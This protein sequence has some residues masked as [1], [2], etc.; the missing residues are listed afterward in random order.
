[1]LAAGDGTRLRP[2]TDSV[3]KCLLP[4]RGTPMLE[5]WLELCRSFGIDEV[6]VN[7]RSH[8]ELVRMFVMRSKSVPRITVVEEPTLL[9]SAGTL[10][11][12]RTWV[13]SEPFFWV[14]YAD[15][16]TN[17]DL[18]L[19]LNLHQERK[20]A[21]TLGTYEVPDPSRCGIVELTPDGTIS[22]FTEKPQNPRSNLAFAGIL[23]GTYRLLDAI[24]DTYPADIGFDVLP[25]LT[26]QMVSY[27]IHDYL[28]DMG[29]VENYR[30]AQNT[31]PG[32]VRRNS[33]L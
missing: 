30:Q 20:P 23:I 9:G 27:A 22:H 31:W 8:A 26:G 5:I 17:L 29:T 11:E 25:R 33:P 16:L 18:R 7:I 32:S 28:V 2:L 21:A 10:K 14:F 4:I 6:L 15:V 3:P 19:M 12:N 13:E 24:P 1:L